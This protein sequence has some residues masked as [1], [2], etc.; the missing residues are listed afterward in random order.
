MA[1][2]PWLKLYTEIMD[3]PK[4]ATWSGDQFRVFIMLLCLAR[5]A[6]EPGFIPMTPAEIS[7]RIRRPIEEVE[8]TLELCQQGAR[9]II[10]AVEGGYI[11]EKLVYH[12]P[13]LDRP[14]AHIWAEIRIEVF[15]RDNYTCAYCGARGVQLECDHVIPVSRGGC[16]KLSNLVTACK[17][18]NRSKGAKMLEEW[19]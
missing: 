6:E 18:C 17:P 9:P 1:K 14:P 15:K 10:T 2:M 4:L 11:M 19:M 3:D 5:E 16:N 8:S 7:W 12:F 13:D